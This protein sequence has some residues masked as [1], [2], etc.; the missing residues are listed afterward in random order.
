MKRLHPLNAA[1]VFAA[2][3]LLYPGA[4]ES[5]PPLLV[6]AELPPSI[7]AACDEPCAS[8]SFTV[9]WLSQTPGGQLFVVL[10]APC[11]EEQS[12]RS[13]L[14]EKTRQGVA[15]LLDIDGHYR[16]VH[17]EGAYPDVQIRKDMTG[18]RVAYSRFAW[19]E[20]NYVQAEAKD[21]YRV[22]GR[23]CGT[24]D[25]CNAAAMAALRS[26]R[27]GQALKIWE[28]VHRVSWI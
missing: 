2:S 7:A 6:P 24:R 12:C 19:R 17:S 8:D 4:G 21:L 9:H 28:T 27:V 23:E 1:I 20:G 22:D 25:E 15:A 10:P 5:G 18:A 14:V 3:L 13:W 16:L 26:Q 11:N